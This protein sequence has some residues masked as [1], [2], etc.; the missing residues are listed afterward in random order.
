MNNCSIISIP[1]IL[2]S[3]RAL[4]KNGKLCLA[5]T[6]SRDLPHT[7]RYYR[8]GFK[9]EPE[10]LIAE[11]P[12]TRSLI[13]TVEYRS[14]RD[15]QV[16]SHNRDNSFR[17]WPYHFVTIW[18]GNV[19]LARKYTVMVNIIPP[20]REST[21]KYFKKLIF[22]T[23]VEIPNWSDWIEDYHVVLLFT[24]IWELVEGQITWDW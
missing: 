10:G 1:S 6:H 23:L 5:F 7:D 9:S 4:E 2:C 24:V 12:S 16:H 8:N 21:Q 3:S 11:A 14:R 18:L 15:Y 19:V 22:G 13:G 17:L 20:C